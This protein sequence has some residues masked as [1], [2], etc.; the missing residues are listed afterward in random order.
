MV[1]EYKKIQNLTYEELEEMVI[2]LENMATIANSKSIK[3]LI[4]KTIRETKIELEKRIK[5]C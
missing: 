3:E 1:H 2:G 5:S 4:L